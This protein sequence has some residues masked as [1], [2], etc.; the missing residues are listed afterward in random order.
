MR[1]ALALALALLIACDPGEPDPSVCNE[2][3]NICTW[4]GIDRK[5][6]DGD[7]KPP[8][9]AALYF[10][11]D[12]AFHTDGTPYIAD[13]N[14]HRIRSVADGLMVTVVGTGTEGDL[15]FGPGIDSMLDNPTSVAVDAQGRVIIAA[16]HNSYIVRYVPE[17]GMLERVCGDGSRDYIGEDGPA[18]DATTDLPSGVAF[19]QEGRLLIVDQAN[20]RIRRIGHDGVIHSIVGNGEPG[21][22][23][24]GGPATEAEIHNPVGQTAL[25]AGR[26]L[27]APDGTLYFA[28]TGNNRVRKIAPDGTIT[29]LA[30][31]GKAGYSGDGGAANQAKLN[32]PRDVELDAEGRVYIADSSN[33]C[34]RRVDTDGTIHTH[35]GQCG[36]RSSYDDEADGGPAVEAKLDRPYGLAFDPW[37]RL[38]IV[39]TYNHRIRVVAP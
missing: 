17:T 37:N 23:G 10:P 39:D 12:I 29:T 2:P 35:A 18:L 7:G 3:G 26:V 5:G 34:V 30:G 1:F 36:Q 11:M 13:W 6:K 4:A 27:A 22:G 32:E 20:Q 19:D 16:W 9:E 33:H 21:Y 24:D 25:P 14:N 15:A 28:D 31:T 8:H 38:F